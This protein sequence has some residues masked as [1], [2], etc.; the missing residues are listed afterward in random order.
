[1][2]WNRNYLFRLRLLKSF[3]FG[4]GAGTDFSFVTAILHS[5]KLKSRFFMFFTNEY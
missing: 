2:L 3:G 4:S 5:Y 1:V